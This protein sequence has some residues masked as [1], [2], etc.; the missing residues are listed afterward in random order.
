ME[1]VDMISKI[2]A[3]EHSAKELAQEAQEKE[4]HLQA[5]LDQQISQMRES[6]MERAK[7]RLEVV[8]QTEQDAAEKAVVRWN[9]KLEKALRDVEASYEKNRDV[10]AN[11]LF[12]MIVGTMP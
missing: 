10:W 9:E 4:E 7:R 6:Y 2:I 8:R 1:Y 5:D 11:T 3:A 12:A